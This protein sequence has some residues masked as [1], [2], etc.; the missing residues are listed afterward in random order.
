M[1]DP[2]GKEIFDQMVRHQIEL[3]RVSAYFVRDILTQLKEMADDV[4]KEA[5]LYGPDRAEEVIRN[6]D[7]IIRNIY[8]RLTEEFRVDMADV[9]A[10]E[11]RAA[12]WPWILAAGTAG[13][14]GLTPAAT[15]EVWQAQV[16]GDVWHSW[17][18]TMTDDTSR[19]T[20]GM[21]RR[22]AFEGLSPV[23]VIRR[24]LFPYM[25]RR[26]EPVVKTTVAAITNRVKLWVYQ[27]NP[28]LVP[29]I[30]WTA[31]ID[32]RTSAICR[33]LD[34]SRWTTADKK[35]IG[36]SRPWPG[37]PPAHWRCR[38]TLTP[39]KA[40]A[41]PNDQRYDTWL[42]G[43]PPGVQMEVLGRTRYDM[44]RDGRITSVKDLT[45]QTNRP[46]SEKSSYWQV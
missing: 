33:G 24:E 9:I 34:G 1:A 45:D 28:G 13:V 42:R 39:T 7:E 22:A 25:R 11:E 32:N 31:I 19:A 37:P 6:I 18:T 16:S 20:R 46:L 14:S 40:N 17:W 30:E 5:A 27:L 26:I 3:E 21:L 2:T 12:V 36:N 10:V 8:L 44:W 41:P 38:S 23:T 4:A 43:Q 15:A 35:P 29:A